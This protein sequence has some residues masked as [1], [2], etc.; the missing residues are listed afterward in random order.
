MNTITPTKVTRDVAEIVGYLVYVRCNGKA[1]AQKVC[2]ELMFPVQGNDTHAYLKFYNQRIEYYALNKVQW[3]L[4]L[5]SLMA[6]YPR[7]GEI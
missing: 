2:A 4:G 1:F 3:E 7:K 5:E 6:K